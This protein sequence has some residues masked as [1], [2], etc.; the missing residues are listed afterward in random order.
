M[1]TSLPPR[2]TNKKLG[3]RPWVA[4]ADG[5]RVVFRQDGPD[6]AVRWVEE[7][8]CVVDVPVDMV[9]ARERPPFMGT[10]AEWWKVWAL[11]GCHL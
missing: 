5:D 3:L 6:V 2:L 1:A 10:G 7:G 9:R 4:V 8:R 11:N